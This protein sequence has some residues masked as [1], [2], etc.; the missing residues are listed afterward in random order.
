[1]SKDDGD[2]PRFVGREHLCLHRLHEWRL[3]VDVGDLPV[4]VADD[5]TVRRLVGAPGRQEAA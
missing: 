3:A 4:G 5:I 2:P 1:L